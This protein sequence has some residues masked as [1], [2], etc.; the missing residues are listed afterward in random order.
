MGRKANYWLRLL[1]KWRPSYQYVYLHFEEGV[2]P[3]AHILQ[4]E[5][6]SGKLFNFFL[7]KRALRSKADVL[8]LH[9]FAGF[10]AVSC[11]CHYS[12]E[13]KFG[14]NSVYILPELLISLQLPLLMIELYVLWHSYPS[15]AFIQSFSSNKQSNQLKTSSFVH[16]YLSGLPDFIS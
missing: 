8:A 2:S 6:L 13:A 12:I 9:L 7:T 5:L 11:I 15:Q 3:C 4:K 1:Y 14:S 16:A 10:A